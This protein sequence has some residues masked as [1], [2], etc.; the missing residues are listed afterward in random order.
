[1]GA[2]ES[3][4]RKISWVLFLSFLGPS[5]KEVFGAC[6][7]SPECHP[8]ECLLPHMLLFSQLS[9]STLL[10]VRVTGTAANLGF[11]TTLGWWLTYSD[12]PNCTCSPKV[13]SLPTKCSC[14]H[15]TSS[16]GKTCS[17][18][19]K[20][21]TYELSI[22]PSTITEES[23]T[24][25]VNL[26]Q[27]LCPL[28]PQQTL[29][30]YRRKRIKAKQKE[31][32]CAAVLSFHDLSLPPLQNKWV[33]A[34]SVQQMGQ[35]RHS[36]P[37]TFCMKQGMSLHLLHVNLHFEVNSQTSALTVPKPT[38]WSK[39]LS[40]QSE[41]QCQNRNCGCIFSCQNPA[42]WEFY[43]SWNCRACTKPRAGL[44]RFSITHSLLTG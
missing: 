21:V 6:F 7:L 17:L 33:I 32:K 10:G 1:M 37:W 16:R 13:F 39:L 12:W 3:V 24:D 42:D 35:Q 34:S 22:S 30:D 23:C 19:T 18:P 40:Q 31:G 29:L 38:T 27:R 5:C 44:Q 41:Y 43:R 11:F 4:W 25:L 9:T 20:A 26:W 15:E 28:L 14:F 36:L 2:L 8:P